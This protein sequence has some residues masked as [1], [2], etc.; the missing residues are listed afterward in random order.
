[1][2]KVIDESEIFS[3]AISILMSLGYDRATTKEVAE[4]AGVN[5][6][7]L[8]R[9]YGSKA[10]LFERAIDHELADTPLNKLVTTGNLEAD[11]LAIVEAYVQTNEAYGDIIPIILIELPRNPDLKDS[12]TTPWKNLQGIIKTIETYQRRGLLRREPPLA[13][14]SALIGPVMINQM[15]RRSNLDLPIPQV[16]ARGY[17]DAFL[18]GRKTQSGR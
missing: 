7:T 17:V 14:L 13:T 6:V 3:A 5:E 10:G 8:F 1:M 15:F 2:P 18:H 12:I 4:I 9:R 16:D 11:L